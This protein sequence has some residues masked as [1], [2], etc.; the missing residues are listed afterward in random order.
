MRVRDDRLESRDSKPSLRPS[1]NVTP[2]QDTSAS[3][4]RDEHLEYYALR[5][6]REIAADEWWRSASRRRDVRDVFGP[7]AAGRDRVVLDRGN[8]TDALDWL[9]AV[10]GDVQDDARPFVAHPTEPRRSTSAA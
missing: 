7:L 2:P 1:L 10:M 3:D 8:A 4:R 6:Q 9:D 5:R